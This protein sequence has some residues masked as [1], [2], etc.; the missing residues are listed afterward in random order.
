MTGKKPRPGDPRS[1]LACLLISSDS[2][3]VCRPLKGLFL[4]GPPH[5]SSIYPHPTCPSRSHSKPQADCTTE[6]PLHKDRLGD[7]AS[8]AGVGATM[9][10]D[11][12]IKCLPARSQQGHIPP[13]LSKPLHV[14]HSPHWT[15]SFWKAPVHFSNTQ[16]NKDTNNKQHLVHQAP[17]STL[18]MHCL[19][20]FSQ[21]SWGWGGSLS[22]LPAL[23]MRTQRRTG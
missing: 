22:A 13:L 3:E 12:S 5:P 10:H 16:F 20:Q 23:P 7:R 11:F 1:L 15:V 8:G 2:W 18:R 17:S 9:L 14:S 21:Q 19:V 4:P 6:G